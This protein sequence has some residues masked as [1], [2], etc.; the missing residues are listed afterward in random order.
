[1]ALPLFIFYSGKVLDLFDSNSLVRINTHVENISK[2]NQK[3]KWF[4]FFIFF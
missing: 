4:V 2:L 3:Y 1:M